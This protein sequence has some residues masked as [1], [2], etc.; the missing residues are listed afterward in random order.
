MQDIVNIC[1]SNK[2]VLIGRLSGNETR[3]CGLIMNNEKVENMLLHRMTINAGIYF[4][5]KESILKYTTLYYDSICNCDLLAIW[6][7]SMKSQ[8][9]SFYNLMERDDKLKNIKKIHNRVL[10]PY[11]SMDNDTYNYNEICE[12]KKILIISSHIDTMKLQEKNLDKLFQKSIFGNYKSI[13]Y[14]K[15]PLT[16][17]NLHNN[18]DWTYYFHNFCNELHNKDFDIAFV[19]CGGYGMITS[20]YIKKELN[21]SVIYIGGALQLFF[22]IKGTRWNNHNIIKTFYNKYWTN[23]LDHEIPKECKLVENGCYW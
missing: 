6:D 10:E 19:S 4:E 12:N 22:G 7:G 8:C 14:I 2:P 17:C 15:P 18:K 11:Y 20:N 16:I 23:V 13:D 5:N 9:Q 1:N 3:L 21:K